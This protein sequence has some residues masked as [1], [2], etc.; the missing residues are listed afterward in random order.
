MRRVT[1]LLVVPV[2]GIALVV[3]AGALLAPWRD[4]AP[5]SRDT[6]RDTDPIAAAQRR[7][8]RLP[9]DWNTWAELGLAY[10]QRARV[11]GD[12]ADYP[13][14][15]QALGRSLEIRRNDNAVALAGLGALAAA[16]H[17]FPAALRHGRAALAV[18]PYRAAALGVVA[19]ALTELGRYDEAFRT[20]QRMVDLR[21]DA[22]SYARASYTWELRG[23][24][25]RATDAMRRALD[26]AAEPADRAFARRHLGELAFGTGDLGTAATHFTEG[27]RLLPGDPPL[28]TGLARVRA[29]RGDTGAAIAEFRAVLTAVPEPA[30]VA[31]LGDLLTAGGDPVAGAAEHARAR[32]AWA[33]EAATGHPPEA[34]PVLFAADH[35]DPAALDAAR[36]LYT[37]QPG[38]AGADAMGW[39]LRAAGRPAEALRHADQALKL[40]TRSALAHYHRGMILADLRRT[41]DARAELETALRL[42]PYFSTRH[43]PIA[44]ATLASLGR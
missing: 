9:G 35:R 34:D 14:A 30:Y 33:A 17:D 38:I 31:E 12:Q 39:A 25:G 2:L 42:N 43:A 11:T 32:A 8:Q 36:R 1:M 29:A 37:R 26:A 20:V 22:A 4:R 44:R 13:R 40:G 16:R 21:P 28:R 23:D 27:L 18:D 24:V 19:D 41:A 5:V 15:E 10:V 3:T 6:A 7:L